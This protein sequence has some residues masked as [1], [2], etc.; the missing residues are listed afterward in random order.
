MTRWWWTAAQFVALT[1][2]IVAAQAAIRLPAHVADAEVRA[3]P[4]LLP[5]GWV[6]QEF[7][8]LTLVLLGAVVAVL[9]YR[10]VRSQD[11]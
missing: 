8:L 5:G 4:A 2:T 11:R 6:V 9:A 3:L 1:L 10:R 7:G